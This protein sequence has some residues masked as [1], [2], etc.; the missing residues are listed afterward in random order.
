MKASHILPDIVSYNILIDAC[1]KA[2]QL[3]LAFECYDEMVPRCYTTTL[4]HYYT[5]ILYYDTTTV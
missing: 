3:G 1:G 4:L 2:Q 5:T